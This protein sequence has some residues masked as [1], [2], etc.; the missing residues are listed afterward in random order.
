MEVRFSDGA[1]TYNLY[2]GDVTLLS[3]T[4]TVG[5][6]SK[7]RVTD[8][9]EILI[10][11][12]SLANQQ[13]TKDTINSWL[14]IAREM[15]ET[16]SETRIWIE[17]KQADE[18]EWRRSELLGGR[19]QPVSGTLDG[20]SQ[21]KQIYQI[22]FERRNWWEWPEVELPISIDNSTF[23]TG[24]VEI[25]A[26][27][28]AIYLQGTDIA[29]DPQQPVPV[30]IELTEPTGYYEGIDKVY[31]AHN[32]FADLSQAAPDDHIL[33]GEEAAPLVGATAD[34]L[35]RGGQV[36]R[37]TWSGGPMDNAHMLKF[38]L[39]SALLADLGGRW[40]RL[41][42]AVKP[43]ITEPLY[44]HFS[45]FWGGY[46]ANI[47]SPIAETEEV[48]IKDSALGNYRLLDFGALQLP[49]FVP[50]ALSPAGL[51]LTLRLR[52]IHTSGTVDV[53][54]LVL[55]PTD[56]FHSTKSA[57]V[58]RTFDKMFFDG[59]LPKTYVREYIADLAID[60][61]ADVSK[62]VSLWPGRDQWLG[63]LQTYHDGDSSY[64]DF[65]WDI[66]WTMQVWYRP[67]RS[68]V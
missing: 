18:S 11:A 57:N 60:S 54:F 36:N 3:Y 8:S 48:E 9:L 20:H 33:E 7:D 56:S 38:S 64:D 65:L 51:T 50:A 67:R 23:A 37:I 19:L 58:T 44:G 13:A 40:Y 1:T 2:L 46:Q 61:F 39:S 59:R 29:G 5:E 66:P 26:D 47:H 6:R 55:A 16:V 43:T 22:V 52:T 4:P 32:V 34:A 41:L 24:G 49:S 30:R 68:T 21:L 12:S 27:G 42:L 35:A 25:T 10:A 28:A 14:S 63:I 53:D 31:I 62:H 17:I 15:W 45:L